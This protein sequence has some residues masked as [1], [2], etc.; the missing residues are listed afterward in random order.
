MGGPVADDFFARLLADPTAL[1]GEIERYTALK[2]EVES[3][4]RAVVD[5]ASANELL[6][7]ATKKLAQ[8]EDA[9]HQAQLEASAI[10]AL[11]RTDAAQAKADALSVASQAMAD[12]DAYSK[13]KKEAADALYEKAAGVAETAFLEQRGMKEAQIA[14]E[15]EQAA[16]MK[17]RV[18][19]DAAVD[20]L[21]AMHEKLTKARDSLLDVLT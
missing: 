4:M 21:N 16:A 2:A 6:A 11:A 1:A 3:K 18:A 7:N 13:G 17:A 10:V 14:A 19:Y 12:S 9:L 8:A 5:E 15:R 20:T